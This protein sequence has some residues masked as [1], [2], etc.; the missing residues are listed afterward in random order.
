MTTPNILNLSKSS[1]ILDLTKVAPA[2]TKA[3]C[4]LNW[5][6][7]LPGRPGLDLDAF[8]FC[9]DANRKLVGGDAGYVVFYGNKNA[10]GVNVPRDNRSGEGSDDEEVLIDFSRV[11][12]AVSEIDLFVFIFEASKRMQTFADCRGSHLQISDG[13]TGAPVQVYKLDQ[14]PTGTAVNIGTFARKSGGWQFDPVGTAS[15]MG[16]N[17]V[18]A[19]FI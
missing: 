16:P 7:A 9:L 13:T 18:A 15:A 17:D 4:V 12:A 5:D 14:F 3:R 10:H 11:P 8:A 1:G 2:M 19:F 6:P